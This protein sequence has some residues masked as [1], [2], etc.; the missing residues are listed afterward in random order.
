MLPRY[1]TPLSC[2]ECHT[3]GMVVQDNKPC[4][5]PNRLEVLTEPAKLGDYAIDVCVNDVVHYGGGE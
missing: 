5:Q 2:V 4:Q 1:R 3:P